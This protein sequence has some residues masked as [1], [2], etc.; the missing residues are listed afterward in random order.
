MDSLALRTWKDYEDG[1]SCG[2]TPGET[3]VTDALLLELHRRFP[4]IAVHRLTPANE[5]RVGADWEWWIGSPAEG[6]LCLRIQAKRIYDIGYRALD[7]PGQKDGHYQYDTLI[8]NCQDPY[9]LPYHVFYNGWEPTRFGDSPSRRADLRA[10]RSNPYFPH[11]DGARHKL[12]NIAGPEMIDIGSRMPDWWGCAALSTYQVAALHSLSH[13]KPKRL[14]AP[15]YLSCAM[16][17]SYLF[18]SD[19]TDQPVGLPRTPGLVDRIHQTLL[20][21][22]TRSAHAAQRRYGTRHVQLAEQLDTL[23]HDIRNRE[24]RA[25]RRSQLPPYAAALLARHQGRNSFEDEFAEQYQ[26]QPTYT[27]ITDVS[28]FDSE[29]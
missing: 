19:T 24:G 8:E 7:H 18:E 15:R 4:H 5:K 11:T 9:T 14:Y 28:T 6:W 25:R 12:G 17:W 13:D 23:Q 29:S 16:P 27:L 10:L 1:Y 20:A 2:L 21:D 22:T 26:T 3:S